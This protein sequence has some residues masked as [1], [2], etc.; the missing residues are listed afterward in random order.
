[1]DC[2]VVSHVLHPFAQQDVAEG[3]GDRHDGDHQ[4]VFRCRGL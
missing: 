4:K 1:V 2:F 3:A